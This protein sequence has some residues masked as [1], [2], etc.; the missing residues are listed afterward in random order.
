MNSF[1]LGQVR[2][3]KLILTAPPLPVKREDEM[4]FSTTDIFLYYE[5]SDSHS[6]YQGYEISVSGFGNLISENFPPN[7][8]KDS[9]FNRLMEKSL[10]TE[11]EQEDGSL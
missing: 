11:R 2:E 9:V 7:S 4:S 8:G 1:L 10:S 3:P 6:A 5:S